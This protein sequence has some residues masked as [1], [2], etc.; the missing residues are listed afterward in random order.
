VNSIGADKGLGQ[1][2]TGMTGTGGIVWPTLRGRVAL[3]ARWALIRPSPHTGSDRVE[4]LEI[5][6]L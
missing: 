6:T 2:V 3:D 1:L 5:E 4:H